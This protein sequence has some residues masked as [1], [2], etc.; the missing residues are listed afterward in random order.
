[1]NLFTQ[2]ITRWDWWLSSFILAELILPFLSKHIKKIIQESIKSLTMWWNRKLIFRYLY[3][4]CRLK[5]SLAQFD[6]K[7]SLSR[8][9][10]VLCI[11][12]A[13]ASLT[14][15]TISKNLCDPKDSFVSLII[16][17]YSCI[18]AIFSMIYGAEHIKKANLLY[19]L[20]YKKSES[21]Y[22]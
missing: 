6:Q 7:I 1:M 2:Y 16:P 18:I 12:F 22:A 9:H 17:L 15:A 13:L 10:S 11:L 3:P 4:N 21:E 14:L 20:A 19:K 8:Y 5:L